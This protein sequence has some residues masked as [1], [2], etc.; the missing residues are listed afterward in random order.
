MLVMAYSAFS[1]LSGIYKNLIKF[2]IFSGVFIRNE[3]FQSGERAFK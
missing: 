1:K 2:T 3:V